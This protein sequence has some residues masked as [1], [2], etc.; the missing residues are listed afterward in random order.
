[1]SGPN[2]M[3]YCPACEDIT[4]IWIDDMEPGIDTTGHF[5]HARD[6]MCGNCR[7]VI[8]TTYRPRKEEADDLP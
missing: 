2:S 5:C 3:I 1:M 4:P 7:L 8:A 6:L